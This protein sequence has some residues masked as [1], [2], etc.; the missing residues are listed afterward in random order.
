M[1]FDD[2][3]YDMVNNYILVEEPKDPMARAKQRQM[4]NL[5]KGSNQVD[6]ISEQKL[7]KAISEK[8]DHE[9][10]HMP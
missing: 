7:E 9:S 3:N 6:A 10:I 2:Y 5:S 1:A 8:Y 4:T